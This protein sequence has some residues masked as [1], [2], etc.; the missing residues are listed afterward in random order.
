[1]V[2]VPYYN[3]STAWTDMATIDDTTKNKTHKKKPD[4]AWCRWHVRVSGW[5][6]GKTRTDVFKSNFWRYCVHFLPPQLFQLVYKNWRILNAMVHEVLTNSIVQLCKECTV[7]SSTIS[8]PRCNGEFIDISSAARCDQLGC[9]GITQGRPLS[10]K[11]I[12]ILVDAVVRESI[13]RS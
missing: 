8:I 7:W 13:W 11:L 6:V 3:I 4:T 12:N 10:A 9:R 2:L 5:S 1:M